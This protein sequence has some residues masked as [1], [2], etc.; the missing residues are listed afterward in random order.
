MYCFFM[1]QQCLIQRMWGL[2]QKIFRGEIAVH[3]GTRCCMCSCF[4]LNAVHCSL[5]LNYF[6][7]NTKLQCIIKILITVV[8]LPQA[9]IEE[10]Y[11]WCKVLTQGWQ[12]LLFYTYTTQRSSICIVWTFTHIRMPKGNSIITD[13]FFKKKDQQVTA[14]VIKQLDQLFVLNFSLTLDYSVKA[15][16]LHAHTWEPPHTQTHTED[17]SDPRHYS[18]AI[19]GFTGVQLPK[20]LLSPGWH[21]VNKLFEW[22]YIHTCAHTHAL[23]WL[24]EDI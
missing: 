14:N 13:T 22:R 1:E 7:F 12:L 8:I 18:S 19:Q 24:R 11:S 3:V 15:V 9:E 10:M 16:K 4:K 21:Q 20:V 2:W 23:K 6:K 5:V 17:G